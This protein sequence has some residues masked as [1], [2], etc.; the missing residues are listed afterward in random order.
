MRVT[1]DKW[2]Y[3]G[4]GVGAAS[5]DGAVLSV[6]FSIPGEVV[7][8]SDAELAEIVTTSPERVAPGC[9][10]F[11]AC[12][13]CQ[14]QHAT[15]ETQVRLKAAILREMLETTG[16]TDL[17]ELQIHTD[18]PWE[19][20]NRIRLRVGAV[21]GALRVGYNRRGS[22]EMLP[23][24]ECPIAAPLLMRTAK[25]IL[26]VIEDAPALAT[27]ARQI[28]EV[29]LFTNSDQSH[30]QMIL[31][32]RS[33]RGPDFTHFCEH[34]KKLIPEL[35]GAGVIIVGA[36]GKKEQPG[37][38]WGTDGLKYRAADKEYWVS[39]GSFFQVNRFLVDELVRL[40]THGRKG[41]LA[42]DLYAGVGLFSRSLADSF[43]EV[44]GVETVI[45]DLAAVLKGSGKRAVGATTAEFLRG[46]VLQ[47]EKPDLIV[48][49]PPRA[50]LGAEVCELLGRVKA[51]EMVYVSCDPQTLARD[52][53]AMV[54]SGYTINEVHM[55][56]LFPQTFHMETV[57]VLGR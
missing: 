32:L 2:I 16:L 35:V 15:Y 27:W 34:L 19:Y 5:G 29:E 42:W 37:A 25:A 30:L 45:G 10:H 6:P 21:D 24:R 56:D 54:D 39:R 1:I 18:E 3:G 9:P 7:E 17:P 38:R 50:G 14:Y 49:D 22:Y 47:R 20:R 28:V 55:L 43:A 41:A 33:D 26:T 53:K 8:V 4:A 44:V 46:A 57:V 40:V 13:G 31:F 23:I 48:M 52:L 12:G 11:G 36:S 51:R